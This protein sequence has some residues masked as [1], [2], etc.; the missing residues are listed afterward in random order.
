MV[1]SRAALARERGAPRNSARGATPPAAI[2]LRLAARQL[3]RRDTAG[4]WRRSQLAG[5]LAREAPHRAV[6]PRGAQALALENDRSRRAPRHRL[7]RVVPPL[8]TGTLV[9]AW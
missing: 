9:A 1:G 4:Q 7:R 3:H 5:V 6:A 2:A 8:R